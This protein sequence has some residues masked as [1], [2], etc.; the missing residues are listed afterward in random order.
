MISGPRSGSSILY[1]LFTIYIVL[2]GL[3]V[4]RTIHGLPDLSYSIVFL[5]TKNRVGSGTDLLGTHY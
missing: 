4:A 5:M 2:P 3:H 1:Q